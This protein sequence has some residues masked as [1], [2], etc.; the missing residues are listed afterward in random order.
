MKKTLLFLFIILLVLSI[1][2]VSATNETDTSTSDIP[3]TDDIINENTKNNDI[4]ILSNENAQKS[5]TELENTIKNNKNTTIFL[6]DDYQWTEQDAYLEHGIII[7][8]SIIID[9]Q[10]HK[11]DANHKMRIFQVTNNITF[12]NINF[13]NGW[14]ANTGFGGA[15][16]NKEVKNI[17]IINCTF[18]G[19]TASYGGAISNC[20][21]INCTFTDNNGTDGGVIYSCYAYPINVI[22][23]TFTNNHAER[24]GVIYSWY[25][26]PINVINCIFTNNHAE[27]DGGAMHGGTTINCIFTNN[28]AERDGGAMHGG[29]TINCTFIS[30]SASRGGALYHV[31]VEVN[32]CIFKNNTADVGG[33]IYANTIIWINNPSYFIGNHAYHMGGAIYTNKFETDVK[34]AVFINNTVKSNDDGGAIYINKKNHITFTQCYFENNRCGDEG[35]AIYLDSIFSHLSLRYNIFVNNHA[36]DKGEI[37]YNKGQYDDIKYNWYGIN[38]SHFKNQMVKYLMFWPDEDYSDNNPVITKLYLNETDKRNTYKL[39]LEFLLNNLTKLSDKLFLFNALFNADNNAKI[40][41]YQ[42]ENNK[43]TSDIIFNDGFTNINATINNQILKL[44]HNSSIN[45]KTMT[46]LQNT[47]KGLSVN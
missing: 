36:G 24:G 6:T 14:T 26:Y 23:C 22:N 41:N 30:N 10:G 35:G 40:N 16:W 31:D 17:T 21:A 2:A 34:Y 11:I 47:I 29:T 44:S 13:L 45:D 28:H 7:D 4:I 32:N 12:K 15:V 42:R 3:H 27:R 19:N 33:A 25:A 1:G 18:T 43:I 46:E 39:T 38:N 5:M 8:K 37:I 20:N 9:G